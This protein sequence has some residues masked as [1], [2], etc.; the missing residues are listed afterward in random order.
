MLAKNLYG[1]ELRFYNI[2]VE[3]MPPLI[4][5]VVIDKEEIIFCA[6]R[7]PYLPTEGEIYLAVKHPKIVG[8]F[9]DYYDSIW[10]GA[11]KIKEADRIDRAELQRIQMELKGQE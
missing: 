9:Q 7:A 3:H 4:Q 1:Y 11:K 5:Y 6:Y 2:P 10:Q 8:L